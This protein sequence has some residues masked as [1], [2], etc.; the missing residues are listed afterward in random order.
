MRRCL[1]QVI[2]EN[3]VFTRR[4]G[5]KL[6]ER[7]GVLLLLSVNSVSLTAEL[8]ILQKGQLSSRGL[9]CTQ[10]DGKCGQTTIMKYL[11]RRENTYKTRSTEIRKN[12]D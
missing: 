7:Q 1:Q 4:P 9:G 3:L 11:N 5:E 10:G 6:K 8:P 2:S 12:W